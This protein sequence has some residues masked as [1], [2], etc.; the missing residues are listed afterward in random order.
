MREFG[1]VNNLDNEGRKVLRIEDSG[2]TVDQ[3]KETGIVR[4]NH[5][6]KPVRPY[7]TNG[8]LE[9]H[10]DLSDLAFLMCVNPADEGGVSKLVNSK[11]VYEY[12]KINHPNEL[13][14]L[15][16]TKYQVHHQTPLIPDGKN[17]LISIPIFSFKDGFFSS[18]FLRTYIL[19]TNEKLGLGLS[20]HEIDA[21]NLVED[22]ANKLSTTILLEKGDILI[23]N[24]HTTYHSRT[25]FQDKKT[26]DYC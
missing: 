2:V 22:V 16:S 14:T 17:H 9:F 5:N 7:M 1:R 26:R 8:E 21:L 24:N 11:E 19:V 20:K 12:I 25:K 10:T 13:S 15:E 18:F 3:V 23:C 6:V 4:D